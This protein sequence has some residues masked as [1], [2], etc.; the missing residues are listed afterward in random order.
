MCSRGGRSSSSIRPGV[1]P[2]LVRALRGQLA[3]D[4]VVVRRSG[5]RPVST[6]NIRPG[7]SRPLA[8]TLAGSRSSTPASLPS[9]TRPS[10]VRH[11]RARAQP[12]AVQHRADEGAVGEGDAGRAVP[13]LHQAG[14][15]PV[16]G[17]PGRRPSPGRSPT[18]PG[19]S[20]STACG[21]LR[22]A[23]CSS[24]STSSK[25]AESEAPGVQT[26]NSRRMLPGSSVA[27][28]AAAPRGPHPVAVAPDRVDL[29]VVRDEPVRVRQRPGR[30]RV[31]G[32]P[33]SAPARSR[34][35]PARRAGRGR[36]PQLVRGQHA[37]VDDGPGGQR[38]EVGRRRPARRLSRSACLRTQKATRSSSTPAS[39]EPAGPAGG[40]SAGG[41]R[42]R[43]AGSGAWPP[44]RSRPARSGR[45]ARPA[46]RAPP[47]PRPARTSPPPGGPGPP[48]AS[49]AG[50]N[51]RPVAYCAGRRQLTP[52]TARRNASGTWSMIPA[53]SPVLGSAPRAPRWSSRHSAASPLATT[54]WER[55]PCRSATKATPHG[56]VLL[57]RVVQ[58]LV[59]AGRAGGEDLR[60]ERVREIHRVSCRHSRSI[61]VGTTSAQ[62][63][64]LSLR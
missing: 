44:A 54:S 29:T 13:R 43:P 22:P 63:V 9:T 47:R 21:R 14:V 25:L 31:G 11:Q 2:L 33:A 23:R 34:C 59:A 51:T 3:L 42:G 7:C 36:T 12:V 40:R 64:L 26:G 53:P 17:P 8:T 49:S 56:V 19:S 1:Q 45:P 37:L 24:S 50:R 41:R 48:S 4:L 35:A 6:R 62:R 15:E 18:P 61:T 52:A 28:R 57:R 38:R 20:S 27:R 16:E 10:A 60:R 32:E 55:R 30:E 5:R 39:G 46:R 58:A